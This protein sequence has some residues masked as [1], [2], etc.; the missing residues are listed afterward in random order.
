[1]YRTRELSKSIKEEMETIRKSLLDDWLTF[2]T[3][4]HQV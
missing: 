2:E 3:H 4:N 1:M